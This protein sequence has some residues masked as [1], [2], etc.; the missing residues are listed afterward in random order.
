MLTAFGCYWRTTSVGVVHLKTF[1]FAPERI[2]RDKILITHHEV[3]ILNVKNKAITR[4]DLS[5]KLTYVK[6]LTAALYCP[7][8]RP[9]N[10][11][12]RWWFWFLNQ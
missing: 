7:I 11:K 6:F 1:F 12:L 8:V 5:Q 9:M 4:D 2:A 3:V 10:H